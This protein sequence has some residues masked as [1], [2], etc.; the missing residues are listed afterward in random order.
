MTGLMGAKKAIVIKGSDTMVVLAQRWAERFSDKHPDLSIQVS[1]GGSGTGIAALI[2]GTTDIC[3]SSRRIKEKEIKDAEKNRVKPFE[4]PVAIDTLAV[5]VNDR[6]PL[7]EIDLPTLK[8]IY[9][10]RITNWKDL[11]WKKFPI[12]IYSRESNSGTYV[13]FKEHVLENEDYTPKAQTLAG[14]AAVADAVIKDPK[15]I[16]YGGVAYFE[17]RKGLRILKL[18]TKRGETAYTASK[19][20]IHGGKYPLARKLFFYTNGKPQ[21]AIKQFVDWV[22]SP[23]GQRVTDEVGYYPLK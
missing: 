14:T 6:N 9:T 7:N 11:G 8:L 17:N 22:L 1:G 20:N 3:T 5:V 21:G 10:G 23:D 2:N 16:G 18:S 4:T 15:A 19:E 13:Y 12:A